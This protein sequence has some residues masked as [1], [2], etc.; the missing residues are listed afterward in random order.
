MSVASYTIVHVQSANS[1]YSR[2]GAERTE[3]IYH[4]TISLFGYY[5]HFAHLKQ[6]F[7]LDL[8]FLA[9]GLYFQMSAHESTFR[10]VIVSLDV[11][12]YVQTVENVVLGQQIEGLKRFLSR[13]VRVDS[14]TQ[15][16]RLSLSLSHGRSFKRS[17]PGSKNKLTLYTY[18]YTDD[19][20]ATETLL[21][22]MRGCKTTAK[23]WFSPLFNIW[24]LASAIL[25]QRQKNA[26]S[27][28]NHSRY[29]MSWILCIKYGIK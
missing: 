2:A 6:G 4:H 15:W 21:S 13:G 9:Q 3:K 23:Q 20:D 19:F 16:K 25:S 12:A 5:Y 22:K 14:S 10:L 24:R 18:T 1:F 28:H 11:E 17:A 26:S 8:K 7:S 27:W 29:L